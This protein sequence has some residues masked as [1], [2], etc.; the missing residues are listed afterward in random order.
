MKHFLERFEHYEGNNP[1]LIVYATELRKSKELTQALK[2]I[3]DENLELLKEELHVL[4]LIEDMGFKV[5]RP[6]SLLTDSNGAIGV[7]K[8]ERVNNRTKHIDV[9]YAG[10][11][12]A[13]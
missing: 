7:A 3:Y 11:A 5:S 8:F 9:R 1:N 4:Y 2:E 6:M 13:S 12:Y 10:A